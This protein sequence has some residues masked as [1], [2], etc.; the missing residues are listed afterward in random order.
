MLS[1]ERI[2]SYA[3]KS[4]V[5]SF[6]R[7][8][9]FESMFSERNKNLFMLSSLVLSDHIEDNIIQFLHLRFRKANAYRIEYMTFDPY[10]RTDQIKV[11]GSIIM[12]LTDRPLPLLVYFHPTLLHKN[13]ASGL[14]QRTLL[15]I[16]PVEDYRMMLV[17]LALQGYIVVAPDYIGYGS[18]ENMRH[19][20]LYKRAVAHTAANM[21]SAAVEF[22]NKKRV[23]FQRDLFIMGYSQGGHGAL[24]FAS[25]LQNSSMNFKAQ[26]VSAGGGPYDM[27]YT[28]RELMEQKTVQRFLLA[29]LLQSYS[30]IY[31]WNLDDI[32]KKEEWADIISSTFK[33]ESIVEAVRDLPDKTRT[34]L[35]SDFI[36]DIYS[37]EYNF[38]QSALEENSVYDWEPDFP[39]FLFHTRGDQVV[40]YK[41]ME[42]AY[43]SFRASGAKVQKKDCSFKKVEDLVNI[44]NELRGNSPPMEP[45]HINCNF[46]FFL[47][48]GDYFLDYN[49]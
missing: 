26:A 15:A 27:L 42:I 13:S 1:S 47:E 7:S 5:L 9:L 16:D 3:T 33:Y 38:Y 17:F 32:V 31:N 18:S 34:L 37:K 36:Q 8:S 10:S 19:P 21:L 29:L 11:S 6:S 41:N 40:P 46:I 12:P 25:A 20:Y 49:Y 30:S 14:M 48:T 22:L 45:D 23:P 43:R 44:V 4:F 39:L 2:G 35:R 24:A 28:V